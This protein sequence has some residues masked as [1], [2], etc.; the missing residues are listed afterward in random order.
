MTPENVHTM[1]VER[2]QDQQTTR[3][4]CPVCQ[5]CVED[6]PDGLRVLFRGD[7]DARHRGGR[8]RVDVD[9]VEPGPPMSGARDPL[10]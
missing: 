9:A 1:E 4:T 2:L 10:H 5:R 8:F 7:V 3:Y 6:G